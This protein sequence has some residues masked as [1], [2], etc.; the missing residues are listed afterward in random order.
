MV[1]VK[2]SQVYAKVIFL[3][4][5]QKGEKTRKLVPKKPIKLVSLCTTYKNK[6]YY[7]SKI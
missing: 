2:W 4:R 7:P 1:G 3:Q 5:A 6:Y